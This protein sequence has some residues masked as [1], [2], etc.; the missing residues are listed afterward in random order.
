MHPP[1]NNA[2]QTLE[3][4][5]EAVVRTDCAGRITFLNSAAEKLTGHKRAQA[6]GKQF[7]ELIIFRNSR[8]DQPLA[9]PLAETLANRV[10]TDIPPLSR[11]DNRS[12]VCRSVAGTA[13]PV[14]GPDG[15]PVGV[16]L[17][18]RD[19]REEIQR[20]K[21]TRILSKT[22]DA[23]LRA[24]TVLDEHGVLLHANAAFLKMWGYDSAQE[25]ENKPFASYLHGPDP[26]AGI[27]TPGSFPNWK[28]ELLACK[29]SGGIFYGSC[30]G[31][32]IQR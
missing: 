8:I 19:L 15:K 29:K 23:S 11:L 26:L 5:A 10:A 31:I 13:T 24:V 7:D 28:G 2:E 30:F 1:D 6:I 32:N 17:I 16:V 3:A 25:S 4:M 14:P 20:G 9:S 21:M 27:I 18:L 22:A 12:G